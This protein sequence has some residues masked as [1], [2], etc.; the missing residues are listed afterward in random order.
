MPDKRI[1][2][3]K[4]L[5]PL[6]APSMGEHWITATSDPVEYHYAHRTELWSQCVASLG[7]NLES[8]LRAEI[9]RLGGHHAHVLEEHIVPR[10]DHV[11]G[12]YRLEGR[13]DYVLFGDV[14]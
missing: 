12:T 3:H 5:P 8:R 6:G 7:K 2:W 9:E 10:I 13:Y 1:Y 4:E 11:D 14:G